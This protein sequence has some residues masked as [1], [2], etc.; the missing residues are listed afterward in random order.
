MG[1]SVIFPP[2][3]YK[4]FN[5]FFY[6]F[7]QKTKK[8]P[9]QNEN[10]ISFVPLP[11][12]S[13]KCWLLQCSCTHFFFFHAPPFRSIMTQMWGFFVFVYISFLLNKNANHLQ[14]FGVFCDY[15]RDASLFSQIKIIFMHL[16]YNTSFF[17][18]FS[19][20]ARLIAFDGFVH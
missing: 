10:F 11:R 19:S 16:T 4:Q 20:S 17:I 6:F 18:F 5:F 9:K 1:I 2:L 7:F 12:N 14:A 15:R 8:K 13:M 3:H